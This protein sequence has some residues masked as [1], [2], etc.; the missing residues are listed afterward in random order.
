MLGCVHN[1]AWD[2]KK[3]K[4]TKPNKTESVSKIFET[5]DNEI[6][7]YICLITIWIVF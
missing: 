3:Q 5:L 2:L 7:K 4:E 6:K 1:R